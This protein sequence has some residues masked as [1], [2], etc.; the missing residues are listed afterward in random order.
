MICRPQD[1]MPSRRANPP[2]CDDAVHRASCRRA[3]GPVSA[4]RSRRG[5]APASPSREARAATRDFQGLPMLRNSRHCDN[6]STV[7]PARRPRRGHARPRAYA[8][9][10]RRSGS[11]DRRA[12]DSSC[13]ADAGSRARPL[14][15][16]QLSVVKDREYPRNHSRCA[17]VRLLRVRYRPTAAVSPAMP[18][19]GALKRMFR[20]LRARRTPGPDPSQTLVVSLYQL[21]RAFSSS[22]KG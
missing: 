19:D 16:E 9:A 7:A 3:P 2:P 13:I 22:S 20:P 5:S 11:V 10:S 1:S 18:R 15:R 8:A 6:S 4:G 12:D 17:T 21:M 14:R